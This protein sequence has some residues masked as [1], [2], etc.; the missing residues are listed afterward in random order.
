MAHSRCK[1]DTLGYKYTFGV[2]NVC[3]F[4][5][6]V[7]IARKPFFVRLLPV[8]FEV[9]DFLSG[10]IREPFVFKSV[11]RDALGKGLRHLRYTF[12]VKNVQKKVTIK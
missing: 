4:S 6:A 8:L 7:K 11:T 2:C 3:R 10:V 9:K 5:T 12:S 1:L